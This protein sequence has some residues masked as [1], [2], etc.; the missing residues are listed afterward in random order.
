MIHN[1]TIGDEIK[2][3]AGSLSELE[4]VNI[5][6]LQVLRSTSALRVS[7]TDW[8]L[9]AEDAVVLAGMLEDAGTELARVLGEIPT[10]PDP[11]ARTRSSRSPRRFRRVGGSCLFEPCVQRPP[12]CVP[13]RSATPCEHGR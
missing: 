4:S 12:G 6:E 8:E 9:G 7:G 5:S 10:R 2:V 13:S 1:K 3:R 11:A